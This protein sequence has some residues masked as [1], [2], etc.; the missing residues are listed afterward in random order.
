[1]LEPTHVEELGGMHR[2]LYALSEIPENVSERGYDALVGCL[3]RP[4]HF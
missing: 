2:Y 1:M 4:L 3:Q